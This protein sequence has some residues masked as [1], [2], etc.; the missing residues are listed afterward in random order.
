M[1]AH[2]E[3]CYSS[4]KKITQFK[5]SLFQENILYKDNLTY[6]KEKASPSRPI[7]WWPIRMVHLG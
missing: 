6:L 2:A 5:F 1:Y 7:Q 4:A 3:K